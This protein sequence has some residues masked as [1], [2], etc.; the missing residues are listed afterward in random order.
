MTDCLDYPSFKL[1]TRYH[2]SVS[3]D[4]KWITTF[5]QPILK[6]KLQVEGVLFRSPLSYI[7]ST[8][9]IIGHISTTGGSK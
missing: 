8:S 5:V 2:E 9:K 6:R 7:H 1:R 4:R 3:F